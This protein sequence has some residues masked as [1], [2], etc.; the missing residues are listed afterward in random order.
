MFIGAPLDLHRTDS[1][2]Q[3]KTFLLGNL[4]LPYLVDLGKESLKVNWLY[5]HRIPA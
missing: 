4:L 3:G 1:L 5:S 2:L